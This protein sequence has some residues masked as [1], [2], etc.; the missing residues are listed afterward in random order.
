MTKMKSLEF[1]LVDL[2]SITQQ[3]DSAI[4]AADIATFKTR[5]L[6]FEVLA[7]R[8]CLKSR[9]PGDRINELAATFVSE[10]K[11]VAWDSCSP[12]VAALL[13]SKGIEQKK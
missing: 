11:Q 2:D 5:V 10:T 13:L 9:N 12:K 1:V 7:M 6:Q 8:I 3:V 4:A